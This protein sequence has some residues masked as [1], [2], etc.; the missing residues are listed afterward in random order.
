[1]RRGFS[2][3]GVMALTLFLFVMFAALHS[4]LHMNRQRLAT[5]KH[6]HAAQW[7]AVSGADLA[8]ARLLKGDMKVGETIRSPQFP[9]GRFEVSSRQNGA[10]V[11][12]VSRGISA[13]QTA[14]RQ[15]RVSAP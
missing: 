2:L 9:Q 3:S 4:A 15:V 6:R 13:G 10:G 12:L 11:L 14:E 7:L 5:V 8:R 1:M